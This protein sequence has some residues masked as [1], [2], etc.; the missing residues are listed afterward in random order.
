MPSEAVWLIVANSAAGL[1]AASLWGFF[2]WTRMRGHRWLWAA[3]DILMA[4]SAAS[5]GYAYLEAA[6]T[7]S[8]PASW[9]RWAVVPVLV[10]PVVLHLA[11]WMR[12]RRFI[13]DAQPGADE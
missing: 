7:T 13:A 11:S 2:A 5:V 1:F 12:A 4:L 3:I 8:P 10:L 6:V 9:L